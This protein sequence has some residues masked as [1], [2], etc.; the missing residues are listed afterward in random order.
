MILIYFSF[1]LFFL[2]L[3]LIY[4]FFALGPKF[5]SIMSLIVTGKKDLNKFLFLCFFGDEHV[6]MGLMITDSGRLKSLFPF[7]FF[8]VL[9]ERGGS[10]VCKVNVTSLKS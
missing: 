9:W 6:L 4:I 2:K 10:W 7:L 5:G 3:L 8:G 1:F